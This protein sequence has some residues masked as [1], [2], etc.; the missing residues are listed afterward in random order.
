MEYVYI[1]VN[2]SC[3]LQEICGLVRNVILATDMSQVERGDGREREREREILRENM[4]QGERDERER[5]REE[6]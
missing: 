3:D 6:I 2:N 1:H 5:E 4:I